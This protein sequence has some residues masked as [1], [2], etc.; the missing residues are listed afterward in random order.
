ML[1][2]DE[3]GGSW[4]PALV[5]SHRRVGTGYRITFDILRIEEGGGLR[6]QRVI[7]LR[8]CGYAAK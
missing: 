5:F 3:V 1:M 6:Y 7:S 2:W 4:E 8:I